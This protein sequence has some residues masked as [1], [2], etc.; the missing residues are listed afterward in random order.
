MPRRVVRLHRGEGL[1][2]VELRHDHVEQHEIDGLGVRAQQVEGLDPVLRLEGLEPEPSEEPHEDKAVDAAVI[3]DECETRI[4]HWAQPLPIQARSAAVATSHSARR[5]CAVSCAASSKAPD[6]PA[7]SS[8][9]A[10]ADRRRAPSVALLDFKV[11]AGRTTEAASPA[12]A[13]ASIAPIWSAESVRY[14]SMSSTTNARSPPT[15]SESSSSTAAS[16]VESSRGSTGLLLAHLRR[17]LPLRARGSTA[18][19][20]GQPRRVP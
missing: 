16:S 3:D 20:G 2:A 1:V 10:A 4:R 17:R 15:E 6:R 12:A 18:V 9:R 14:A 8:A 5:V 19:A 11:C 13:A 7:I